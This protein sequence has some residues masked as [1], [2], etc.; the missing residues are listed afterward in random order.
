[1]TTSPLSFQLINLFWKTRWSFSKNDLWF[2]RT[3]T[4]YHKNAGTS[5]QNLWAYSQIR[6]FVWQTSFYYSVWS[7]KL[8]T[9]K[10]FL[11]ILALVY[12]GQKKTM[13]SKAWLKS[14]YTQIKPMNIF[15]G[16]GVFL[17]AFDLNGR[18]RNL[19]YMANFIKLIRL[20]IDYMLACCGL[21]R[22][23]WEF[24]GCCESSPTYWFPGNVFR[25]LKNKIRQKKWSAWSFGRIVNTDF[26]QVLRGENWLPIRPG[27]DSIAYYRKKFKKDRYEL[28]GLVSE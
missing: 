19:I 23:H 11:Y 12:G 13:L 18:P 28:T 16:T 17:F 1:M 8:C 5:V 25:Y 6:G 26:F 9:G 21:G 3:V 27:F 7:R 15:Y 14:A 20:Y 4:W 10:C 2:C 24:L 22:S